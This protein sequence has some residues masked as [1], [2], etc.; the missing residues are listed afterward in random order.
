M[1]NIICVVYLF[2]KQPFQSAD[3]FKN[4]MNL[5]FTLQPDIRSQVMIPQY[6]K[7]FIVRTIPE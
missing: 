4:N 3:F 2:L 7:M 6:L 1:T 5:K